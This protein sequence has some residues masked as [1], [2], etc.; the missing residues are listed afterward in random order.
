MLYKILLGGVLVIVAV[1]A[2]ASAI[3]VM[4]PYLA[5]TIVIGFISWLLISDEPPDDS[6]KK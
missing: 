5:L 2:I 3:V 1:L 6:A 4:A